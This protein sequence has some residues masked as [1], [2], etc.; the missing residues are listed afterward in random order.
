[1]AGVAFLETVEQ[2]IARPDDEWRS[3]AATHAEGRTSAQFLAEAHDE[4]IGSLTVFVRRAGIPDYLDRV[5]EV[6][7]PTVVGV[8]VSPSGRGLGVV[9]TL[10]AAASEWATERGH[11]ELTLDV[12]ES[13]AAAIGAYQRAGFVVG[14]E[15]IVESGRELS[16]VKQLPARNPG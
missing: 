5:P 15:I 8:Y 12:H 7:L 9:D 1:M 6:D 10:L 13:N 2:A 3:R 16:M 14:S 11:R 4:L